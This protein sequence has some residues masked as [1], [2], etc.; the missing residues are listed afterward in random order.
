[1]QKFGDHHKHSENHD[2]TLKQNAYCECLLQ[3]RPDCLHEN[4]GGKQLMLI[5][6]HFIAVQI[7]CLCPILQ[8]QRLEKGVADFNCFYYKRGYHTTTNWG[9]CTSGAAR[10]QK[11]WFHWVEGGKKCNK[12]VVFTPCFSLWHQ[13]FCSQT[14]QW[15]F[16][17]FIF[18]F[19]ISTS[20]LII[21]TGQSPHFNSSRSLLWM[22][23]VIFF[24]FP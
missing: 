24:F 20:K 15:S 12:S 8:F 13:A 14:A 7:Q 17:V 18:F 5:Y 4:S 6:R 2:Y 19:F 22:E 16:N 1:M 9:G 11:H 21:R 10:W 23:T 3:I